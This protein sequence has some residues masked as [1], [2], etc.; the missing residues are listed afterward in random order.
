MRTPVRNV[1]PARAWSPPPSGP[2]IRAEVCQAGNDLQFCPALFEAAAMSAR[3]QSPSRRRLPA[4][5]PPGWRRWAHKQKPSARAPAR[6]RTCGGA[7]RSRGGRKRFKGGQRHAGAQ[8]A[9]KTPPAQAG[10]A[11]GRSD[12]DSTSGSY[13]WV[14]FRFGRWDWQRRCRLIH[15]WR[16]SPSAWLATASFGTA[17]IR[18]RLSTKRRIG[19]LC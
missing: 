9:Q 16:R 13:S 19:H 7:A 12:C 6:R 1:P 15:R 8:A 14:I 3:G 18:S 2:G 5:R 11:F 10:L 4:T 17:R